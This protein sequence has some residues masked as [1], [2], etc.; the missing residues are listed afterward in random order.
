M[1]ATATLFVERKL[2][3]AGGKARYAGWA[4]NLW[5]GQAKSVRPHLL[6]Q[7]GHIEDVV[8]DRS[9][10]GHHLGQRCTNMAGNI[11]CC[12]WAVGGPAE[13]CMCQD[14]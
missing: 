6:L 4:A 9:H 5:D 8:V 7:V 14:P 10:R 1:V 12:A 3:H 13:F 11:P 2:I